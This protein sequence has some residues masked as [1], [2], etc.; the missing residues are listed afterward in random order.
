RDHLHQ[1][2]RSE[3]EADGL[4]R[5]AHRS[6][7]ERQQ[8]DH[9]PEADHVEEDREEDEQE[10]ARFHRMDGR[11]DE[12]TCGTIGRV[13]Y[14]GRTFGRNASSPPTTFDS[15]GRLTHSETPWTSAYSSRGFPHR[16]SWPSPGRR[17]T[18]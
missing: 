14:H 13:C 5:A 8:R 2:E 18:W 4:R 1:G 3:D 11:S 10:D 12:S 16:T 17:R 9:D 15:D 6:H 7:V